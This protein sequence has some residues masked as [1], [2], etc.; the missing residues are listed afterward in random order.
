MRAV[1]PLTLMQLQAISA[2]R[3]VPNGT[4]AKQQQLQ[5]ILDAYLIVHLS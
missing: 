4:V 5:D 2:D 3:P 1:E